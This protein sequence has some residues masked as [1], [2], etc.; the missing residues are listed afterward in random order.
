MNGEEVAAM[1]DELSA[2]RTELERLQVT[3]ADR[4]A[5]AAHLEAQLS[6]AKAELELARGEAEGRAKDLDEV[7]ERAQ[8]LDVQVRASAERYRALVLEHAPELP[9]ELVAGESVE[10]IEAAVQR[11]R[12][13]V[14][15]VRGH[16]ES[17]AQA[18]RVPVGAPVRSA[19][20]FS[21]LPAE[22]KIR[23]G[24]EQRGR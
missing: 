8:T 4:E 20:D 19:P 16:L 21:G 6:E 23:L 5:R 18:G 1:Q 11:A 17:Q 9:E 22:E 3:L 13:T 14:S 10:E 7:S 15:K 12:E 24:L 2:A